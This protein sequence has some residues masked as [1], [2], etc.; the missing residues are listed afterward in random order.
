MT[1]SVGG[2]IAG[3]LDLGVKY[4][5]GTV[6]RNRFS[7][8]VDTDYATCPVTRRS[9]CMI[10]V[11]LHG[12]PIYWKCKLM[13]DVVAGTMGTEYMGLYGAVME[14]KYFRSLF[15]EMGFPQREPTIVYCDNSTAVQFAT[16]ARITQENKHVDIKYMATKHCVDRGLVH[17][18]YKRTHANVADIGTRAMKDAGQFQLLR[19][20]LVRAPG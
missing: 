16:T 11:F 7:V 4:F 2:Y 17:I 5:R 6:H 19:D 1:E 20:H 8:Y 9:V 3:T 10:I 13:A 18:W 12:G 14:T 15:N